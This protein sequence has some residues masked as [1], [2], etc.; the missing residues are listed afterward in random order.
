V[1]TIPIERTIGSLRDDLAAWFEAADQHRLPHDEAVEEIAQRR[2][3]QENLRTSI[4][5][6]GARVAEYGEAQGLDVGPLQEFL[7][8]WAAGIQ[9][10][11]FSLIECISEHVC[12]DPDTVTCNAIQICLHHV[13]LMRT[14]APRA[15]DP[16]IEA[17]NQEYALK[18]YRE[19][20]AQL[21]TITNT[22]HQEE[23]AHLE[24]LRLLDDFAG[25][26]RRIVDPKSPWPTVWL[27]LRPELVAWTPPDF[28]QLRAEARANLAR[29]RGEDDALPAVLP[30][31]PESP[32]DQA[33]AGQAEEN[34]QAQTTADHETSG[35]ELTD[36]RR[37]ILETMLEH[38]ITSERRRKSRADIV[39]LINRTHK[40]QTYNRDFAALVRGGYLCSLKGPEGGVWMTP[41]GKAE[42]ES[43]R[44]SN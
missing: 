21:P 2:S 14:L 38:E 10:S 42:A 13:E 26:L 1:P 8:T 19:L 9:P 35:E 33:S 41:R 30:F 20:I 36:R 44:S 39:E 6:N 11:V 7:Q 27:R 24:S 40:A 5:E 17:H 32:A 23:W 25:I 12:K 37:S 34:H 28:E 18:S 4:Q 31:S 43:P 16:I 3:D 15:S 22:P 29:L